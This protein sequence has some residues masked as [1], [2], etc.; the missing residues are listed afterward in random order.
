MSVT[1]HCPHCQARMKAPDTAV[2]HNVKCPSCQNS[3]LIQGGAAAA[4]PPAP[5]GQAAFADLDA[6]SAAGPR[7]R[8]SPF[9]DFLLFRKMIAPVVIQVIFWLGFAGCILFGLIQIGIAVF[10]LASTKETGAALVALVISFVSALA[11]MV[12]GPIMLRVYCE[13]LILVFRMYETL[14]EIKKKL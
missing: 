10:A 14:V 13:M 8:S 3:F 1:V 9:V 5:A 4:P 2:G 12:L 7:S 6:P 11:T